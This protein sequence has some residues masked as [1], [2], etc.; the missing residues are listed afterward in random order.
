[1]GQRDVAGAA[2]WPRLALQPQLRACSTLQPPLQCRTVQF[3]ASRWQSCA[4]LV[5]PL[6]THTHTHGLEHPLEGSL[7]NPG[8]CAL[9]RVSQGRGLQSGAVPAEGYMP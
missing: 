7:A 1:M 4:H 6:R 9:T 3:E 5:Q 8:Q 2:E